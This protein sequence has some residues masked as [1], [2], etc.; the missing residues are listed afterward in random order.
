MNKIKDISIEYL[1]KYVNDKLD[2][3]KNKFNIE[4]NKHLNVLNMN[5]YIKEMKEVLE[6]YN[7][8]DKEI[9]DVKYMNM[10]ESNKNKYKKHKQND[11]L[12]IISILIDEID[13][14]IKNNDIKE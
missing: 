9:Y 4:L 13:T 1:I 3:N 10:I 8:T 7:I 14:N 5:D 6:Y 12:Q 11:D 2:E